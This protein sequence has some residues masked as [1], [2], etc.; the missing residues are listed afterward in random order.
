EAFA[1]KISGFECEVIAYDKYKKNFNSPYAKE[2]TI[3]EICERAHILTIHVPLNSETRYLVNKDFIE[4]F[5]QP[6]YLI[7]TSR[8][9]VV[10]TADILHG[11]K[12]GN[13]LGA[14]LDVLENEK[15]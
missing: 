15:L 4:S 13:L 6:F 5:R 12:K 7:N 14:A 11:I 8:G 2:S 1:K 3:S 9:K 10:Q